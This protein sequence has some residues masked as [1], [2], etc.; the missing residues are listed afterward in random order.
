MIYEKI[1][2]ERVN[3]FFMQS[4][5]QFKTEIIE[6]IL[7]TGWG[8]KLPNPEGYM[9][10]SGEVSFSRGREAEKEYSRAGRRGIRTEILKQFRANYITKKDIERWQNLAIIPFEFRLIGDCL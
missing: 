4:E 2:R 6:E 3:D 1:S 10:N 5:E 7:L 9:W 8:L